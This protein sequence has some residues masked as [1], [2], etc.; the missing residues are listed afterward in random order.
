MSPIPK[1]T[2]VA[3]TLIGFWMVSAPANAQVSNAS[4]AGTVRDATGALL[5]GVTIEATSQALI[6]RVRVGVTDDLGQYRIIE[7]RPGTY[8]VTFTLPGCST[9]KVEG[10][11]LTAGFTATVNGELTVGTLQETV[12]VTGETPVVDVQNAR[13]TTVVPRQVLD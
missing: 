12:T 7:L 13:S 4:L 9:L 10:L 1:L 3:V 2:G 11:E 8:T 6:E 5:P